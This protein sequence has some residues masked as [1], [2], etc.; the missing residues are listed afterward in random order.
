MGEKGKG[1]TS[2]LPETQEQNRLCGSCQRKSHLA[3]Q[4]LLCP[5][6]AH[7]SWLSLWQAPSGTVASASG[8]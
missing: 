7:A 6:K 1:A 2:Q 5:S 8:T 4:L 3:K